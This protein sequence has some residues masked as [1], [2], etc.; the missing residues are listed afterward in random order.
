MITNSSKNAR[1]GKD[2]APKT[3]G[4]RAREIGVLPR[5]MVGGYWNPSKKRQRR[6]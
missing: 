4:H 1:V 2:P 5:Y 6:N 3:P